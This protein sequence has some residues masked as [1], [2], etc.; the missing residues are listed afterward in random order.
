M[1]TTQDRYLLAPSKLVNSVILG[2]IGKAQSW[3]PEIRLFNMVFMSNHFHLLLSTPD[4]DTLSKF[5][6]YVSSN[7]AREIGRIHDW[8]GSFWAKRYTAIAILDNEAL[9]KKHRYIFA[10][11]VKENLVKRPQDW[12][13]VHC[14]EALSDNEKLTGIW[15]NRTA[16][17]KAKTKSKGGSCILDDFTET[18]SVSLEPLPLWS[19]SDAESHDNLALVNDIIYTHKAQRQKTGANV[20]G[21]QSILQ[22]HPHERPGPVNKTPAPLC[23]S[24]QESLRKEF[25]EA[26]KTFVSHYR[27]ALEQFKRGI[28]GVLF[29]RGSFL[30]SHVYISHEH[31]I[32]CVPVASY[33]PG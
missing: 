8:S 2:V 20:L 31:C 6:G 26:Y 21:R 30:S 15:Y 9:L 22:Q 28:E 12:P 24:S 18:V 1:K 19:Y 5:M 13:G 10:H 4:S 29:P 17:W 14:V 23:H 32:S 3:Y 25:K 16:Y 27:C 33:S 11:G 7:I